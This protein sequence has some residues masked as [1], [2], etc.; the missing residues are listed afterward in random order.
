MRG[1]VWP[2][3]CTASLTSARA[4]FWSCSIC[5][6]RNELLELAAAGGIDLFPE[7]RLDFCE[8]T[9]LRAQPPALPLPNASDAAPPAATASTSASTT[10]PT[11]ADGRCCRARIDARIDDVCVAAA[12][13]PL[14]F[15]VDGTFDRS[16]MQRLC[17]YIESCFHLLSATV[18]VGLV[19]FANVVSI[20]DLSASEFSTA[21]ALPVADAPLVVDHLGRIL[22]AP[23]RR[24]SV[25]RR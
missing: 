23:V 12:A 14:L 13:Q 20:Y 2:A 9:D 6:K 11:L 3:A 4:A 5:S 21:Y 17:D 7:L 15:L 19:V 24:S 1:R 25:E 16:S 10:L 8:F 22:R 18:P